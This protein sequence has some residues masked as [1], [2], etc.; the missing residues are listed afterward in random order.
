MMKI[1]VGAEKITKSEKE[2]AKVAE[3]IGK[4]MENGDI[5]LLSGDLGAG[6]TVFAKGFVK[7][8][9]IKKADVVSPTFTIMNDYGSGEVLHFDLYRLNSAAEFEAAGLHEALF[10]D[11]VKLVEWPEKVGFDYFPESSYI[12]RI[13]KVDDKTRRITF[14]RGI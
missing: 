11:G 3:C 14:K 8:R 9:K 4:N 2:T 6:K 13:E 10:G 1:S 7:G 5:L 12:V